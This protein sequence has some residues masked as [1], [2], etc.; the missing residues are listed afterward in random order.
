MF[1]LVGYMLPLLRT[2][3]FTDKNMYSASRNYVCTT[4][5]KSFTVKVRFHYCEIKAF[6]GKNMFFHH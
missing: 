5:R 6:I 4:K 1:L 3:F 2:M